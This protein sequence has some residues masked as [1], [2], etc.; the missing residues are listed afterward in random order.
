MSGPPGGKP[1][2]ERP[3][4]DAKRVGNPGSGTDFAVGGAAIVVARVLVRF[5]PPIALMAVIWIL[6]AQSH[7]A[8]DLGWLD[9]V[10]RKLAH[11][12]EF[13]L[14]ALLWGRAWLWRASPAGTAGTFRPPRPDRPTGPKR[15]AGPAM[16]SR[17]RRHAI[18]TGAAVAL[19]WAVVDE[20]HQGTVDG[21]VGTPVDV[22]VDTVG[23]AVAVLLWHRWPDLVRRWRGPVDGTTDPTRGHDATREDDRHPVRD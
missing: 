19:A 13:G 15:P 14:L 21:R 20:L 23:I 10:L 4:P 6:S 3:D 7:L 17:R 12:T 1:P 11:M 18:V 5:G 8:T 16:T 9:T 2:D 22:L